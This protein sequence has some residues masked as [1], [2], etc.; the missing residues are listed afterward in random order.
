MTALLER[1]LALVPAIPARGDRCEPK[2]PVGEG[3]EKV[4]Q[5]DL[6]RGLDPLSRM[7]GDQFDG[8]LLLDRLEHLR[9]PGNLLEDCR[10]LLA[11]RG[12]L[13]V[14][15]PN[16]VNFTMRLMVLFGAFRYADRGIMDWS[17]LRF[18]TRKTIRALLE[19]YGYRI[20]ATHFTVV[21]L[22][23]LVSLRPTNSLFRLANGDAPCRDRYSSR[24]VR[25]R[26]RSG[27]RS[28]KH[29]AFIWHLLTQRNPRVAARS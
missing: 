15:V 29:S 24:A 19:K 20:T 11:A 10:R 27:S 26:D 16:A 1:E 6:E 7:A 25:L 5:A 23:R 18:F 13:I 12:K 4:V 8:I 22:E 14:S 28:D 17:H 3:Y 9:E 2:V 21:P